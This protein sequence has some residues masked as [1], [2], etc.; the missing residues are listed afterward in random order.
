MVKTPQIVSDLQVE[1]SKN[2]KKLAE[3]SLLRH[4][5]ERLV[6]DPKPHPDKNSN[7]E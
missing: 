1:T 4:L 3:R 5:V 6:L 2:L 7:S